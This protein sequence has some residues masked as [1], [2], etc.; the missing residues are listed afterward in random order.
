M[1]ISDN[2]A[3]KMKTFKGKSDEPIYK[4]YYDSLY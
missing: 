3:K 4:E 2:K 1:S